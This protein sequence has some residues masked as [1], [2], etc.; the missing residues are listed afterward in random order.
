MFV[1][2][3]VEVF[4]AC[5]VKEGVSIVCIP[6]VDGSFPAVPG[7]CFV[8]E[9]DVCS[10]DFIRGEYYFCGTCEREGVR[11]VFDAI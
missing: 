3:G 9:R 2:V 11:H 4:S 5:S 7:L 10:D 6:F 8:D 1:A